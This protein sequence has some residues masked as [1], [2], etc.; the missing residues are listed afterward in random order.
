MRTSDRYRTM[1]LSWEES[2]MVAAA[3]PG[4]GWRER[5]GKTL[6][7]DRSYGRERPTISRRD[8]CDGLLY[9]GLVGGHWPD[10]I[11]PSLARC[12]Q[13]VDTCVAGRWRRRGVFSGAAH[14]HR[15]QRPPRDDG[16]LGRG[17]T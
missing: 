14:R 16:G 3:T 1:T 11:T 17:G 8:S 10:A 6:S 4:S 12:L 9:S 15:E 2:P 5:H 7:L 13:S